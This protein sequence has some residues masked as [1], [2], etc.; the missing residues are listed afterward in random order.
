MGI[1]HF[2][3]SGA[4]WHLVLVSRRTHARLEA[5][6]EVE[7]PNLP[8][9]MH[10]QG[11]G[12]SGL[13]SKWGLA[14]A[15]CCC[16]VHD[17]VLSLS[18]SA[19]IMAPARPPAWSDK[20]SPCPACFP[21]ASR[22]GLGLLGITSGSGSGRVAHHRPRPRARAPSL[23]WHSPC[24]RFIRK[25]SPF[26]FSSQASLRVFRGTCESVRIRSLVHPLCS[27]SLCLYTCAG[28]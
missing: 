3:F 11:S 19:L 9:I 24:S 21:A 22:L 2:Q 13:L 28:L 18:L 4:P 7:P 1:A 14:L 26:R 5:C 17:L 20:T 10:G 23:F 25:R 8:L 6:G 15:C 16:D 12:A 27:C